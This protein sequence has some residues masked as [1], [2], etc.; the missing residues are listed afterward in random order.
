[1]TSL[2]ITWLC[3]GLLALLPFALGIW[4]SINRGRNN[5]ACGYPADPTHA[6]H[7]AA[8]AHGNAVEYIPTLLVL[9]LALLQL[10]P[11]MLTMWLVVLVT[12]GRFLHAA[13]MLTC[14]SLEDRHPLRV[15]GAATTYVIGTIMAV[16]VIVR[17]L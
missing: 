14:R 13:G 3:F 4:V 5:T 2:H 17:V 16:L 10:L 12:I 8:R 11:G 7:K 6:L 1:M 9:T 15:A